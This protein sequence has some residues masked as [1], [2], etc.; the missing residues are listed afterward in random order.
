MTQE[1]KPILN[2]SNVFHR[3]DPK[4]EEAVLSISSFVIHKAD[5]IA[6]IG[7]NGAGKTTLLNLLAGHLTPSEGTQSYNDMQPERDI[8]YVPEEPAYWPH[9]SALEYLQHVAAS[10]KI[11]DAAASIQSLSENLLIAPWLTQSMDT[12]S[13]GTRQ[14]VHLAASILPNPALLLLDEP[15]DGLDPLQQ[16]KILTFLKELSKT[17]AIVISTHQLADLTYFNRVAALKEGKLMVD[18][19]PEELIRQGGGD[20]A[21]AY[22]TMMGNR[23]MGKH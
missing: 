13:K 5:M 21:I 3:F 18:S 1:K 7:P 16:E 12:L 8:S 23:Q 20:P 6:L 4:A 15:T 10:H 14:R 11:P 19:T 9:Q 22:R 2:L 17:R